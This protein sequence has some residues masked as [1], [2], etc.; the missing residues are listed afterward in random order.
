MIYYRQ[1]MY[2]NLYQN[3]DERQNVRFLRAHAR[4]LKGTIMN[5]KLRAARKKRQ[6]SQEQAALAIGIDRKTYGRWEQGTHRPQRGTLELA[7]QAFR[8]SAV[9]LGFDLAFDE[10]DHSSHP[11]TTLSPDHAVLF[12]DALHLGDPLMNSHDLTK[13]QAFSRLF[14]AVIPS[15]AAT[16]AL[17]VPSI[18]SVLSRRQAMAAIIGTSAAA[19]HL[20]YELGVPSL[21]PEETILLC[22]SHIPLCWSLYFEGGLLETKTHLTPY[23]SQ[24]TRLASHSAPYQQQAASLAS[25]AYQLSALLEILFHNPKGALDHAQQALLF[26]SLTRDPDLLAAAH[27]R[28]AVVYSSSSQPSQRLHAYQQALAACPSTSFLLKARI[29][30]GMAETQSVL[31][32]KQ[33]AWTSLEQMHH[34]LAENSDHSLF[35]STHFDPWSISMYEKDVYVQLDRLDDAWKVL[36][37][38]HQF[39]EPELSVNRVDLTVKQAEIAWLRGDLEQSS[40]HLLQAAKGASTLKSQLHQEEVSRIY[41]AMKGRWSTEPHFKAMEEQFLLL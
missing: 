17:P 3:L 28:L 37:H 27:I 19:L 29:Y 35:S 40:L 39:I 31:G 18:P 24:L 34:Y 16:S 26:A 11:I 32:E 30:A 41:H 15:M 6:W 22:S 38:S 10:A 9:E 33:S 13:R 25:L 20:S 2:Q 5:E 4:I 8:R 23:L 12:S 7:C 36:E 1:R 21:H 14:G